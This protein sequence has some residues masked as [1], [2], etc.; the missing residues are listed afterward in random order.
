MGISEDDILI[1][2]KK[3]ARDLAGEIYVYNLYLH[4]LPSDVFLEG[5]LDDEASACKRALE[6]AD[7]MQADAWIE[8]DVCFRCISK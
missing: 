6:R 8:T 4:R 2:R 7:E 1:F 3:S 5:P